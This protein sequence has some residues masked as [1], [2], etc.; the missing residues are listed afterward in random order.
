MKEKMV[1]ILLQVDAEIDKID[2][3]SNDI[4]PTSLSMVHRLQKILTGLHNQLQ[5]YIFLSKEEEISFFKN[6]KPELLG[7]LLYFYKIYRIET[8]CPTGSNK[9]VRLYINKELDSLTYF[10]NRNLD[11]YQYYRSNSTI[12][13]EYYF[14]RGNIDIRLCTDSAQF[15]KD[16][17][18]STGYDYKVAKIIAN[19]MLRIYLNK[20][21]IKLETDN[22]IEDNLQRLNKFWKFQCNCPLESNLNCPPL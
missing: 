9:V 6:Q 11:F 2:L 15:D 7:R 16:P 14:L 19:E 4:I 22:Q 3:Y 21:L 12:Y 5:T 10:F 1:E 20:R 8:Q 13:D 17:K 18:F